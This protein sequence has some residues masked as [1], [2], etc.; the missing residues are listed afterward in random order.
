MRDPD[1]VLL[2]AS[3]CY[4]GMTGAARVLD[5]P[6]DPVPEGPA[7]V[8]AA[9]LRERVGR[10]RAA[11]RRLRLL[12]V[13]PDFANP[14]GIRMPQPAREELLRAATELD[15]L[16]LEDNPYG[17]FSRDDTRLPVLKSMT[18]VNTSP[19]AQAVIG[20]VLPTLRHLPATRAGAAGR[21]HRNLVATNPRVH[22]QRHHQRRIRRH[23]PRHQDHRPRRLRLPQPTQPTPTHPLRHHQTTPRM[24]QPR[25]GVTRVLLG[26]FRSGSLGFHRLAV[27]PFMDGVVPLAVELV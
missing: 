20:V 4:L 2:V 3:P 16:V 25:L 5:V 18:T 17:F 24:P 22:P 14:S 12:Y 9:T 19:L 27:R 21:H 13:I 1:D 11:G 7:G 6:I 26:G 15:L 8:A 10:L 23:Q